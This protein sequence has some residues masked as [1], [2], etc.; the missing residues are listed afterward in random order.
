MTTWKILFCVY[1]L[2]TLP[3]AQRTQGIEYF[4]SFN[5]PCSNQKH[6]QALKSWSNFN[7]TTKT[8]TTTRATTTAFLNKKMANLVGS[9]IHR[10]CLLWCWWL[11]SLGCRVSETLSG[12][13]VLL[14][15]LHLLL[16][17]HQTGPTRPRSLQSPPIIQMHHTHKPQSRTNR[18]YSLHKF[19]LNQT[20]P[21]WPPSIQLST[22]MRKNLKNNGWLATLHSV[23]SIAVVERYIAEIGERKTHGTV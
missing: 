1:T 10:K 17:N 4:D 8:T 6:Q 20:Q 5:P 3:K 16:A 11:P 9:P 7:L 19:G 23:V 2:N 14:H 22:I 12:L 13:F 18:L 15:L 21:P